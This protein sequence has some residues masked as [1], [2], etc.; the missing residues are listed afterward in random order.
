VTG[1]LHGRDV[2]KLLVVDAASRVGVE[3]VAL[4]GELYRI[5]TPSD[6]GLAPRV[7]V[8]RG[9]VW[10]GLRPSGRSGPDTVRILL[11]SS[12][13]WDVR[14]PAG[15]GEQ[16]LDLSAGRVS[17]IELGAAGLIEMQLPRAHGRVPV[18][19]RDSVGT[20]VMNGPVRPC[21]DAVQDCYAVRSVQ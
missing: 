12:V 6:G 7:I 10:V 21:G 8:K 15:A 19:F 2:A 18:V 1:A 3:T 5:T 11:N 4:P 13:R 14:L 16:R 17:R 9:L 20:L